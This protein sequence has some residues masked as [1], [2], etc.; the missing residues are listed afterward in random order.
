MINNETYQYELVKKLSFLRYG[1]TEGE[2]KAAQ[3]LMD[4]IASF[5]GK[6]SI[7]EFQIPAY[8]LHKCSMKVTAPYTEEIECVPYGLSGQLPEGGVELDLKYIE[9]AT[10]IDFMGI[11]DLSGT[12]VLINTL[13]WDMYKKLYEHH[14]AAFI[15]I[16]QDKWWNTPEDTDLVPRNLRDEYME[17]GKIPGFQIRS[18]T[19]LNMVKN[20]ASKVHLE[21]RETE[22]TH[23]SRNVVAVIPGT[24]YPDE[25]VV[26]TAHFDSVLVGTGSWDNATGS[27]LLMYLYQYFVKNPAKRTMRFVWCGSEEQGLYGSIAYID[28]HP[29]IIDEIKMDFNFDMNGT[30][31]GRNS[32]SVTGG[33]DLKNYVYQMAAEVGYDANIRVGVSS[34][35]SAP[36]AR[37]GI[38]SIG[39]GRGHMQSCII[40]TRNDL[41]YPLG[42]EAMHRNGEF[43]KLCV[44]RFTNSV[45]LP[46]KRELPDNIKKDVDKYFWVDKLSQL[47]KPEEK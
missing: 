46:I 30:V 19:A 22:T 17:I 38:P 16:A 12:A 42:A 28:Q 39:I 9:L 27:A 1:G 25:S 36:F 43:A 8:D 14:A 20:G 47:K 41:I 18:I 23:T 33:E 2:A 13:D 26:L 34:S 24:E 5:G 45:V 35:D 32:I 37:K 10:D 40:H 44:S 7:E 21:L 29:D 4:E 11:G 15:V 31:L 6:G 3:I